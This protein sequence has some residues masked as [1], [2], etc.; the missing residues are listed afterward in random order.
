[1]TGIGASRTA[2]IMRSKM[3]CCACHVSS[4]MPWRSFRSP[5]AQNARSPA[6]VTTTA[7]YASG[8][9]KRSVNT[10][11]RSSPICVFMALATFGRLSVTWRTC[12]AGSLSANVS[13]CSRMSFPSGLCG[14]KDR[15]VVLAERGR[16]ALVGRAL[17]VERERQADGR[18]G[19]FGPRLQ[20]AD[21]LRLRMVAH[22]RHVL[23]RRVGDAGLVESRHEF[24]D[25]PGPCDFLDHR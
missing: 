16:G 20:D 7:R 3:R 23:Q 13:Y 19:A 6:P 15:F 25:V 10:S 18:Q 21:G 9:A 11:S 5:P 22:L 2:R 24:L 1:M 8:R 14:P 17:T 4:D 12:P